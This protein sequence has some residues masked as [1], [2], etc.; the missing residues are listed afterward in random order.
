MSEMRSSE[1]GKA[2]LKGAEASIGSVSS[3]SGGEAPS[4]S[5]DEPRLEKGEAQAFTDVQ[6]RSHPASARNW[7]KKEKWTTTVAAS[8]FGFVAPM[9]T[10][11]LAPALPA[12]AKDLA[13]HDPTIQ[14]MVLS[15]FAL[16]F[17][18][19][20]LLWG[21]LGEVYGR[22]WVMQGAS[23][24]C[25]VFHLASGFA[26]NQQQMLAFR[27]LAG[28]G[29][30]AP[31]GLC[32]GILADCFCQSERGAA[33]RIY[34]LAPGVATAVGPIVGGFI[35]VSA[36]WRWIFW[37]L[38]VAMG[39]TQVIGFFFL[40]ETWEPILVKAEARVKQQTQDLHI[41]DSSDSVARTLA[42]SLG[43]ATRMLI[44]QPIIMVVAV[45]NAYIFGMMYLMLATFAELY[46]S[47]HYYGEPLQIACLHYIALAAGFILGTQATAYF[48]D[49]LYQRL[50]SRYNNGDTP[51]LHVPVMA[52]GTILLPAGLLMYG[53]CA[54]ARAPWILSDIG[55]LIAS[56]ALMSTYYCTQRY[57]VDTYTKYAAS[58][59]SAATPLKSIAGFVFPLFAPTLYSTLRY[60][61]GN[62]VLALV[63][64]LIGL[65]APWLFWYYGQTLR[66]K[67]LYAA[68]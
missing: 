67:S 60:G 36:T 17:N 6:E 20:T 4:G 13:I 64:V 59:L 16:A 22:V 1:S 43:R 33:L 23:V 57:T 3:T 48:D 46:S 53:W 56:G 63:S 68:G 25:L 37:T 5:D 58:A 32:G 28:F 55:I 50:K 62:S 10:S 42:S 65:P 45:Y 19:G 41:D 35:A 49:W 12:I 44:T 24:V 15:T 61:W 31:Q 2:V 8:A 29:A 9:G 66:A 18:L 38:A 11:M 54:E 40:R 26:Q 34:T 47:P 7:S 52:P 30:S 39:V 14:V 51:E 27:F 21:P